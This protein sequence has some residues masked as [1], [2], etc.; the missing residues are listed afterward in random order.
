MDNHGVAGSI[1]D[2][3]VGIGGDDDDD[4]EFCSTN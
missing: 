2:D 4:G 1:G 3:V